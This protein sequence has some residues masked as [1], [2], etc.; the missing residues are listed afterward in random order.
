VRTFRYSL[1]TPRCQP[2]GAGVWSVVEYERF[3]DVC[4][5]QLPNASHEM[6]V[7]AAI[8]NQP[9]WV[10][11]CHGVPS[12]LSRPLILMRMVWASPEVDQDVEGLQSEVQRGDSPPAVVR[13]D[14]ELWSR[15]PGAPSIPEVERVMVDGVWVIRPVGKPVAS[16]RDGS[17]NEAEQDPP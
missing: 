5:G 4:A 3:P 6:P 16:Q 1:T 14:P 17:Q 8:S 15:L 12:R 10:S 7:R 9:S 11:S 13:N 2:V